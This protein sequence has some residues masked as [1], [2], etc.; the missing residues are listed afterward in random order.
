MES[1]II[2]GLIAAFLIAA[3]DVFTKNFSSKYTITEHLLH[4]YVLCGVFIGMF[5]MYKKY[6]VKERVSFVDTKDL[7]KYILVA[8]LSAIIISPCQILSLKNCKNPGQAKAIVN[9]NTIFL[10][11]LSIYFIQSADFTMKTFLGIGLTT[12]GVYFI[13]Q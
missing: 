10:F 12:A 4:Y 7:W 3:R 11:F 13:M 5:A 6:I 9:L 1:W 2:Y 8:A